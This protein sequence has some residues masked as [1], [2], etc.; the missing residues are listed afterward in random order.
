MKFIFILSNSSTAKYS[1]KNESHQKN[2]MHS[3]NFHGDNPINVSFNLYYKKHIKIELTKKTF[4]LS[5]KK[6]IA[7]EKYKYTLSCV[8]IA[9]CI[10]FLY[11]NF[12]ETANYTYILGKH[13]NYVEL[14][15]RIEY[16]QQS[17]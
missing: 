11:F 4:L 13:M 6:N 1:E 15:T 16:M 2:L 9:I 8:Y 10:Y 3:K 7:L 5:E 14:F 12:Y 17:L